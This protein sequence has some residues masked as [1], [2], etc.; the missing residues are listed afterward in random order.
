MNDDELYAMLELRD[1]Y[2]RLVALHVRRERRLR[3]AVLLGRAVGRAL[4]RRRRERDPA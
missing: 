2:L 3:E 1:D 4:R